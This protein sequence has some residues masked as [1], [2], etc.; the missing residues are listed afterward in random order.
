MKFITRTILIA[1]FCIFFSHNSF[2]QVNIKVGYNGAFT[3]SPTL[4]NMVKLYNEK[5]DEIYDDLEPFSSLHGLELGV[6]YRMGNSA[7]EASWHSGLNSS[8]VYGVIN[9]SSFS[10]K[11]FMSLTEYAL[12]A[13]QYFGYV[14]FGAGLGYRTARMKTDIAGSRRKR[15]ELDVTSGFSAKIFL[16]FQLPGDK[17][18]LAIKPYY[19]IPLSDLN[20][21]G[22]ATQ[23]E[24]DPGIK[25]KDRLQTWG[26][27]IVLYNGKQ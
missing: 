1:G 5:L 3:Q 12:H 6:R 8:D 9:G 27:S 19:Q 7:F 14:G 22:L 15:Q 13:E 24:L 26:I 20:F 11:Y 18:A 10:K 23:M 4:D 17:V 16:V 25:T 21:D 2:G